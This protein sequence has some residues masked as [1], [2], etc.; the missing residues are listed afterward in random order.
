MRE[1]DYRSCLFTVSPSSLI[2]QLRRV[3]KGKKIQSAFQLGGLQSY[4]L[5]NSDIILI[6]GYGQTRWNTKM[7][8]IVINGDNADLMISEFEMMDAT[9][10]A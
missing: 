1:S 2:G 4:I 8:N 5:T 7:M 10:P 9:E 6:T 3:R